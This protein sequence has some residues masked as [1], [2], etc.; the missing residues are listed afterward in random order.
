MPRNRLLDLARSET[1]LVAAVAATSMSGFVACPGV[2]Q[3]VGGPWPW[4]QQ[5]YQWA[6]EQARA[7]VRPTV[8]DRLAQYTD[9]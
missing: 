5:L 8:M 9:N 7:V 1:R 4:Q 3:A 2:Y 6:F